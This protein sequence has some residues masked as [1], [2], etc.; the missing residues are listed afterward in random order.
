MNRRKG[1]A[2]SGDV[3]EKLE[4]PAARG[5]TSVAHVTDDWYI[6]CLSKKLGRK[7]LSATILGT[8]FVIFR[9][10]NGE[11]GALLDR[12]PHRNI[13][14]SLGTVR[15][16]LLECCYHGWQ[17]DRQGD[18][19]IVPGLCDDQKLERRHVKS[20]R[21]REQDGFVW[22]Y[23]SADVEPVR[24]PFRF[25]L[26]GEKGYTAGREELTVE[27][28]VHATS[29]NALDVPH[30]AY[31]HGGLFRTSRGK[32]SIIDVVIRRF[33]DRVEAEYIGEARPAGLIGRLLAPHEGTVTHVDRFILPSITQ[34]EYRLGDKVHLSVVTALTPVHDFYTRIF[35]VVSFRLPIPG[36]LVM[37]LMRPMVMRIFRQ[38]AR[39]LR[40]QTDTIRRFGGEQYNSSEVD[41]LGP[42]IYRL[43][44]QAE[45]GERNSSEAP[46]IRQTRMMV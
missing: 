29:E 17:F 28:S 34:V 32:R 21:V 5:H 13:P 26:I 3:Q 33:H 24:E 25:D 18:C 31:L 15:G 14:L 6:V 12:C 8:P 19:K 23:A 2:G 40:Q 16:E 4:E 22:V 20:Y 36:W 11:A 39:I 9:G 43:L 42:H 30:T 46:Y 7:P 10:R 45:R 35:A 27:S 38:D 41:V 1:S 44:K 37:P